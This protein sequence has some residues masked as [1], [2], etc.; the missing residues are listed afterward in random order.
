MSTRFSNPF[1]DLLLNPFGRI[2]STPSDA[3]S[4]RKQPVSAP[5]KAKP[6]KPDA[7]W[8]NADPPEKAEEPRASLEPTAELTHPR[9]MRESAHFEDVV[10]VEVDVWIPDSIE[11]LTKVE[12]ELY[13]D[14][15]AKDPKPFKKESGHAK[16]G[17]ATAEFKLPHPKDPE[18]GLSAK[19]CA[20]RFTAKHSK[21]EKVS[22]PALAAT[23]RDATPFD[24]AIFYS[25]AKMEYLVCETESELTALLDNAHTLGALRDGSVMAWKM[26]EAEKRNEELKVVAKEAG[27]LF[28]GKANG[29]AKRGFEE[30]ILVQEN[31]RWGKAAGWSYIAADDPEGEA[32]AGLPKRYTQE[33]VQEKLDKLLKRG[34]KDD[35]KAGPMKGKIKASLFETE[36]VTGQAWEWRKPQEKVDPKDPPYFVHTVEAA[37][38]RY[39]GNW[40]GGEIEFDTKKK[41]LNIGASGK[42]SYSIFEGR[43]GLKCELP[44]I[45][46]LNVLS[47]LS[48]VKHKETFLVDPTRKCLVKVALDG[49]LSAFV[50]ASAHAALGLT[51]SAQPDEEAK[52]EVGGFAGAQFG[53][54]AKATVLWTKS[55][56]I[57]FASLGNIGYDANWSAGLG[58]KAGL[59]IGFK[60]GRFF[61]E[62]E[63]G[64]TLGVG[65][66]GGFKWEVDA[67]QAI[68]VI[69]HLFDCVNFHFLVE[70]TSDAHRAFTNYSYAYH[71]SQ[72]ENYK[73]QAE[74]SKESNAE[75]NRWLKSIAPKLGEIKRTL[76]ESSLSH[77]MLAGVPPQALAQSIRTVMSVR[78]Q[79][80]FRIIM[81]L[82]NST[83][84]RRKYDSEKNPT[85][86]HKLKW[87]LR[88]LSDEKMPEKLS[89]LGENDLALENWKGQSLTSGITVL[90]DFGNANGRWEL[91]DYNEKNKEFENK[92]NKLLEE[93]GRLE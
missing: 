57:K 30:L 29:D 11:H 89:V 42:A 79:D 36:P 33:K 78:E 25:P 10:A 45:D 21:S 87:V 72:V 44:R 67:K 24:G 41:T 84:V 70:V 38:G 63:A 55:P 32:K 56:S 76:L 9:W 22:G 80:D 12:F 68:G 47:L 53:K 92:L 77:S 48:K 91:S 8:E 20:F 39:L 90:R 18:T 82:L 28:G 61:F 86:N 62:M 66:S 7:K 88:F 43:M 37:I 17:V 40:D 64:A 83:V 85:A 81:N 19:K 65:G 4:V 6:L 13:L 27:K 16:D 34:Q 69:G 14:D 5:R 46:G 93:N 49:Y 52:A 35:R 23:V 50:G 26:E 71:V 58:A 73:R 60:D 15:E 54:G 59:K 1:D 75:F 2:G 51:L 3:T 31:K 74:W